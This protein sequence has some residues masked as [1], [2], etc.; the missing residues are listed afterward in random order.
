[1]TRERLVYFTWPR[2]PGQYSIVHLGDASDQRSYITDGADPL[3][4][5]SFATRYPPLDDSGLFRAFAETEANDVAILRFADR[6]GLLGLDRHSVPMMQE[7]HGVPI[8]STAG[9]EALSEWAKEISRISA[10]VKLWDLVRQKSFDVGLGN[11]AMKSAFAEVKKDGEPTLGDILSRGTFRDPGEAGPPDDF[12]DYE[13]PDPSVESE[14]K[15]LG[16]EFPTYAFLKQGTSMVSIRT[17]SLHIIQRLV[18]A[19]M[20]RRIS[21]ELSWDQH[22]TRLDLQYLPTTLLAAIWLQFARA[23]DGDRDYRQCRECARWYEVSPEVARTNRRFCSDA[24]RA[25]H[26]RSRK[27]AARQ[28]HADGHA[29]PQIAERFGT[30]V[31]TVRGWVGYNPSGSTT[32][33]IRK[34]ENK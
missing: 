30:D 4:D 11:A 10:A 19:S 3:D 27:A 28:L 32:P 18:N 31:A 14:W 26:Y 20:R 9:G 23:V 34:S 22:H 33:D 2:T 7:I 8:G 1:M 15:R 13:E 17:A 25:K 29:L 16:E 24:C 12:D 21:M 6:Y 5:G